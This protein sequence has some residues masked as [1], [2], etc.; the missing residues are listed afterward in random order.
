MRTL[1]LIGGVALALSLA[2]AVA[3]P[4]RREAPEAAPVP[5]TT[6]EQSHTT[7][8]PITPCTFLEHHRMRFS[9]R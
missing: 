1:L 8:L 2:S 9:T 5:P 7:C 4:V 3:R 6:P